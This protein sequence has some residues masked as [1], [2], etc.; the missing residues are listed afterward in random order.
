M[1]Q[2]I[3]IGKSV[4][5]SAM[6][7]PASA[8][9]TLANHDRSIYFA[10]NSSKNSYIY[11]NPA[12]TNFFKLPQALALPDLLYS[13][14]HPDDVAYVASICG[15]LQP[16]ELKDKIEFRMILQDKKEYHLRLSILLTIDEINDHILVGYLDDISTQKA[17]E[18]KGKELSNKKNAILNIL[19]HDLAG[20]LG[21][22]KN[23]A[24][25][26]SKKTKSLEDQQINSII[27]AIE[28]ISQRSIQMIQEFIKQEFIESVGVDLV[29]SRVNLVEKLENFMEEYY[30]AGNE[31]DKIL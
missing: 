22:I 11:V 28:R 7:S 14:V 9:L 13:M 26:L 31:T 6:T 21:S 2:R 4:S 12:F 3:D 24:F 5:L 29:K 25:L 23:F 17:N 10:F 20:P 18:E 19:S 27:S 16:G 30:L 8:L 1:Y 15:A